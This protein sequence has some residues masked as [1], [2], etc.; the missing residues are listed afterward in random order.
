M[1]TR[2]AVTSGRS[3]SRHG[4]GKAIETSESRASANQPATL[5]QGFER[6]PTAGQGYCLA[7]LYSNKNYKE[8]KKEA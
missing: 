3:H 5:V 8:S 1:G 4:A 6:E 7:A 2:L